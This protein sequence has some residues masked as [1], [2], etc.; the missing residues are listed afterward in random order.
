MQ[1]LVANRTALVQQV[2]LVRLE[3]MVLRQRVSGQDGAHRTLQIHLP[4][5]FLILVSEAEPMRL[6]RL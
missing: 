5:E 2:T 6:V 4:L 1:V 3:A